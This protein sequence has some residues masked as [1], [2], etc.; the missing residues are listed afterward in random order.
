MENIDGSE[1][2][3]EG[4]GILVI[5]GDVDVEDAEDEEDDEEG[6]RAESNVKSFGGIFPEGFL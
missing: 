6:E 4:D 1:D 3:D 2:E 5:E